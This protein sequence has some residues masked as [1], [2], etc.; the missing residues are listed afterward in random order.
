M[1][2][3]DFQR[4]SSRVEEVGRMLNGLIESLQPQEGDW[5]SW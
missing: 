2:K 3:D 5:V 4:L 1:K